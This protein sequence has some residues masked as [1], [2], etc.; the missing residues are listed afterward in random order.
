ML[1]RGSPADAIGPLRK[2]VSLAPKSGLIKILLGQALVASGSRA[3]LDEAIN[4]LTIGLEVEPDVPVG[5]RA[6][7]RAYALKDNIPMAD[8]ATAQ[9]YFTDGKIED[10][11]RH[12]TRA[13]AKLKPNSPAWLRADDIVTYKK[14]NFR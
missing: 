11:K 4:N 8:L 6:L 2:A 3:N 1:E 13:Q 7:A 9:G 5:Y 14:P 10:A 12:A